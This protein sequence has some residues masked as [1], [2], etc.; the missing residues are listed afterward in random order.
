M[1]QKIENPLF[2]VTIINM[3]I[4]PVDVG[5]KLRPYLKIHAGYS[6]QL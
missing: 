4:V 6:H 2:E 3:R 5:D 1:I